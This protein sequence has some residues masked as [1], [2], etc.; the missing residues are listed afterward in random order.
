[1]QGAFHKTLEPTSL[2]DLIGWRSIPNQV[3]GQAKV[4]SR[5]AEMADMTGAVIVLSSI[6]QIQG[7]V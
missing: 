2:T 5:I 7:Y 6:E 1:M 3:S 4:A